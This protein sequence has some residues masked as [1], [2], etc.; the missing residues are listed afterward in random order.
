MFF[1]FPVNSGAVPA[2]SFFSDVPASIV[3]SA[4]VVSNWGLAQ[5]SSGAVQLTTDT[6]V[7]GSK[8]IRTRSGDRLATP[9]GTASFLSKAPS[10]VIAVWRATQYNFGGSYTMLDTT[11]GGTVP[12]YQIRIDDDNTNPYLWRVITLRVF[13][14][15]SWVLDAGATLQ[16]GHF[17]PLKWHVIVVRLKGTQYEVRVDGRAVNYVPTAVSFSFPASATGALSIGGGPQDF[18]CIEAYSTYLTDAKVAAREATLATRFKVDMLVTIGGFLTKDPPRPQPQ[19][20]GFPWPC[21]LPDGRVS[22]TCFNGHTESPDPYNFVTEH[23]STDKG[24]T[25]PAANTRTIYQGD[26]TAQWADP[27]TL[28]MSNG[29]VL[30]T[31]YRYV[32]GM[33]AD[34]WWQVSSDG[35]NTYTPLT[36]V[37]ISGVTDYQVATGGCPQED[38]AHLGTIHWQSYV[39]VNSNDTG[40]KLYDMKVGSFGAGTWTRTLM[41]DGAAASQVYAEPQCIFHSSG[42][43]RCLL[44]N[45]TDKMMYSL[46]SLDSGASWSAISSSPVIVAVSAG[47]GYMEVTL[48]DGSRIE[49]WVA[50]RPTAYQQAAI[51]Y[52]RAGAAWDEAFYAIPDSLLWDARP[53]ASAYGGGVVIDGRLYC[54]WGETTQNGPEQVSDVVGRYLDPWAIV[55]KMPGSVSPTTSSIVSAQT[56]QLT[57]LGAGGYAYSLSPNYSTGTVSNTG[58]YTAGSVSGVQ[59]V[60]VIT[61]GNGYRL[62]SSS[63]T[64][65]PD[66]NVRLDSVFPDAGS[67]AGNT[68]LEVRGANYVS[69]STRVTVGGVDV[70]NT[71]VFVN[72]TMVKA[73][74]PA[75]A[76]LV[77]GYSVQVSSSNGTATR[78]QGYTALDASLV[79][80]YDPGAS[81]TRQL[82]ATNKVAA[83]SNSLGTGDDLTQLQ[84]AN[85]PTYEAAGLNNMPALVNTTST[86]LV[87]SSTAWATTGLTLATV[88]RT[89]QTGEGR[90]LGMRYNADHGMM[91]L[92]SVTGRLAYWTADSTEARSDGTINDG[93]AHALVTT[94]S[95]GIARAYVDTTTPGT[96]TAASVSSVGWNPNGDRNTFGGA[97]ASQNGD[98]YQA[99]AATLGPAFVFTSGLAGNSLA[100]LVDYLR[101]RG[102][103]A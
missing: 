69:G 20:V 58:L 28:V 68:L 65:F 101:R 76:V 84:Q 56:Q 73:R 24:L 98:V 99:I 27:H 102:G 100:T 22:V 10:T 34:F 1:S 89:T 82:V 29:Q 93:L 78:S 77:G 52:R 11:Q 90:L 40:W 70:T 51:Y 71:V 57:V 6:V 13:D 96:E 44:R 37:V 25:F 81:Y 86:V 74:S 32:G 42:E 8:A 55:R 67:A 80:H 7:T 66:P 38:P 23:F 9:A 54:V 49:V 97:A 85:M 103:V 50:G 95:G 59:D 91:Q 21:V 63:F 72:S 88:M 41:L 5:A 75:L 92:E 94:L 4:G 46:R 18:R 15:S 33:G 12:G 87:G 39:Q 64:V 2:L 17:V 14:G 61:D 16:W 3:S 35:G 48:P 31:V 60:V 45:D 79:R 43:M 30:R 62:G 83:L 26:D 47:Q 19:F 36:K 53:G